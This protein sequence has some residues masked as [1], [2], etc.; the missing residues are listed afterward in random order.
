MDAN[1]S[2]L[3]PRKRDKLRSTRVIVVIVTCLVVLASVLFYVLKAQGDKDILKPAEVAAQ[4]S[5]QVVEPTPTPSADPVQVNAPPTV[6]LLAQEPLAIYDDDLT[7]AEDY[8]R[9]IKLELPVDTDL[10]YEYQINSGPSLDF[11]VVDEEN[12]FKWQRMLQG[13]NET[14]FK[15]YSDLDSTSTSKDHKEGRLAAGTYYLI[16]DNTD[17]G[18]AMPPMNMADDVATLYLKVVGK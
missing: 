17:Y 5:G 12:Y 15:T 11:Y 14:Q 4:A 8:S 10:S 16:I 7:V 6:E 9:S 18:A 3:E 2:Q 1:L 13:T